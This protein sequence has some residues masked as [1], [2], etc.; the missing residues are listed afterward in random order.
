MKTYKYFWEKEMNSM[1]TT[2]RIKR[3]TKRRLEELG[4]KND[5]FDDIINKLIDS[6]I[7]T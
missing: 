1:T 2:I 5:T 4:K 7:K 6:Y 3:T